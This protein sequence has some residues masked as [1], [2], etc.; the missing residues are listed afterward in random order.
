M[1]DIIKV[2][3]RIYYAGDNFLTDKTKAGIS[4]YR[5]DYLLSYLEVKKFIR[6]EKNG[7]KTHILLRDKGVAFLINYKRQLNQEK[8]NKIIA[9]TGCIL[10]ILS[11]YFFLK[12]LGEIP[13]IVNVI[14]IFL[15]VISLFPIVKFIFE[16]IFEK[17]I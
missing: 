10:A 6:I 4:E 15:V 3:E 8:F 11:I 7:D 16:T 14:L 1:E 9:F 13:S 12:D 17:K 5:F 2:L